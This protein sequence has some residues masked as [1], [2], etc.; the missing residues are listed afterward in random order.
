MTAGVEHGTL[1]AL[2][3]RVWGCPHLIAAAEGICSDLEG[4]PVDQLGGVSANELMERLS[5]P[6]EKTGRM[7]LVEDVARQLL[8]T[9]RATD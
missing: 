6:V 9:I 7:L 2:R 4:G 1:A 8:A 5:V 3:F